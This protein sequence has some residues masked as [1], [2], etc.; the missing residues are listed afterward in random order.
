MRYFRAIVLVCIVCVSGAA[1]AQ[2]DPLFESLSPEKKTAYFLRQF[3]D[4][5]DSVEGYLNAINTYAVP[6]V[7]TAP[8]G[9]K[10]NG[11][12][13][14]SRPG[15]L[16]WEYNPPNPVLIIANGSLMAYYDKEL[17]ELSY[18]G[19]DDTIADFLIREEVSF[20]R[21]VAIVDASLH[22]YIFSI[23]IANPENLDQGELTLV[24]HLQPQVKL[25]KM[26]V[27]DSL[28]ERTILDFDEPVVN[29]P[30]PSGLFVFPKTNRNR[31]NQ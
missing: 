12:F 17:D 1:L 3:G 29:Q 4:S 27:V 23:T 10:A 31:R 18:V 11:T 14:L 21:D 20:S 13:Y 16:R 22:D 24:F 28:Q 9:A 26:Y 30:L 25:Q 6:Y 2:E 19:M 5:I 15:K 8:N 7:Q